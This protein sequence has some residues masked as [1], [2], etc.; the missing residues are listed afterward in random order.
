MTKNYLVRRLLLHVKC[1]V[2]ETVL[3]TFETKCA[4]LSSKSRKIM[5]VILL[6]V[7]YDV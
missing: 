2:S 3:K 6:D 4:L 5:M 1:S 7:N